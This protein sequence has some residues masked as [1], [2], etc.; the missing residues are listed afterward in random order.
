MWT[1]TTEAIDGGRVRQVRVFRDG[2]A[3]SY[4]DVL[5]RWQDDS[6]FRDFFVALL[7]DAPFDAY[8]WETPPLTRPNSTR[9]FEFIL[10]DGPALAR[11][12]PDPGAFGP[13]F[14][15]DGEG[16]GVVG[17]ANLGGDAFL[18]A[19]CPIAPLEA[20]PH[21]AAFSRNAPMT[22]Q[23]AFWQAVGE[24]VEK[25]LGDRPIWL[26]TSGL[27]VAWLHARIDTVPKYYTHAPYRAFD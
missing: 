3:V 21:L 1:E 25:R 19:P 15:T 9:P 14:R 24:N 17:F 10:A 2:E 18:I 6:A 26:S 23:H 8:F 20:Y 7:I 5:T 12:D 27:G 11:L 13:Y 22:Q 4:R 16:T